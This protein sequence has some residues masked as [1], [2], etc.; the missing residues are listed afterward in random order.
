MNFKGHVTGG[1]ISSAIVFTA[2]SFTGVSFLEISHPIVLAAVCFFMSLFPDFDTASIPQRWFYRFSIVSF[3]YLYSIDQYQLLAVFSILS[4]TPLLHKH[5]GWTHWK[6]TPVFIS[7]SIIAFYDYQISIDG[8][9]NSKLSSE[10]IIF[11]TISNYLLFIAAATIGHYTHLFLDS[12]F[13]KNAFDH[14]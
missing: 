11:N 9:L 10:Y 4:I 1:G 8:L 6:I 2:A 12:K 3:I 5:R 14:H 7:L 13:F